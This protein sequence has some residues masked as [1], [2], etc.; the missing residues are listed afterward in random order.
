MMFATP[1]P[2]ATPLVKLVTMFDDVI[3][4]KYYPDAHQFGMDNEARKHLYWL[5]TQELTAWRNK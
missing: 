1:K 2:K 4:S 3:K 5:L